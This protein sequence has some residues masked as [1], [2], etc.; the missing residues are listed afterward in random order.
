M[1]TEHTM[2]LYLNATSPF[3]RVA[4]ITALEKNLGAALELV[5]TDPW[6]DDP[7]LLSAHP[8][9]RV[10]VLVT[11]QG[12]AI[13]ECLL[14]A[15]HL[16]QMGEMPRLLAPEQAACLQACS[17]G[18]A[19]M[20][21]AFQTVIGRK[22]RGGQADAELLGQRRLAAMQRCTAALALSERMAD[23]TQ[24]LGLDHIVAAVALDYVEF[25]LPE[26]DWRSQHPGL[27]AWQDQMCQ[28]PH[29]QATAFG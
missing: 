17:Q 10:P 3:A 16:D 18:Y 6:S 21:A 29:M 2:Q 27:A 19:L 9:G 12:H 23:S 20:E 22:H 1:T 25:R 4:R 15:L 7:T 28:R 13:A 8:S 24:A 11:A 14:I 26:M 5:W